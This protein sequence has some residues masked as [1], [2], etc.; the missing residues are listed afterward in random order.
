MRMSSLFLVGSFVIAAAAATTPK[1]AEAQSVCANCSYPAYNC[2]LVYG[3]GYLTCQA[4][5]PNPCT[6]SGSCG[7]TDASERI[8]VA[9]DG[10]FHFK[11]LT[12]GQLASL[13]RQEAP[14][15]TVTSLHLSTEGG[16]TFVRSC[17]NVAVD[18]RY[19]GEIAAAIRKVTKD[20]VI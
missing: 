8:Q 15:L 20:I 19:T 5:Q 11:G 3:A 6:L 1:H 4:N 2:I 17:G 12:N 7:K 18:R 9:P 16:R 14:L 13:V 10:S